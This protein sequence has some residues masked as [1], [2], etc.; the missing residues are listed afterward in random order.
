MNQTINGLREGYWEQYWMNGNLMF[1]GNYKNNEREG[2]W[3]QYWMNDWYY[4]GKIEEQEIY[5]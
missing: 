4:K 5:I 3:E 2:Y 1:R